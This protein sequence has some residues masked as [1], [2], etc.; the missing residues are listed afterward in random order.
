M[1]NLSHNSGL[2]KSFCSQFKNLELI[3]KIVPFEKGSA[4]ALLIKT[5]NAESLKA[6]WIKIS[7]FIALN[8]Q[9]KLENDFER[10]NIYLFFLVHNEVSNEVKYQIENDT[11]SSRKIVIVGENNF[12]EIIKAHIINN[13]LTITSKRKFDNVEFKPNPIIWETIEGKI[14]KKTKMTSEARPALE[15]IIKKLKQLENEV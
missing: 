14:L 10:W 3:H 2:I 6:D 15:L 11:F 1:D 12:E 13:N 7:N 5:I 8:F 9:N 4:H